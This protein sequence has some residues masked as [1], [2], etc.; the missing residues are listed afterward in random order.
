MGLRSQPS[1]VPAPLSLPT[2]GVH[3]NLLPGRGILA[4]GTIPT[5]TPTPAFSLSPCNLPLHGPTFLLVQPS[6]IEAGALQP[7]KGERRPFSPLGGHRPRAGPGPEALHPLA[8]GCTPGRMNLS[9]ERDL[10]AAHCP[11]SSL[12]ASGDNSGM[13]HQWRPGLGGLRSQR[14]APKPLHAHPH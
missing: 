1:A 8:P 4:T 2:A 11:H 9:S 12:A 14:H 5:Y 6:H 10:Q 7:V 13:M 3:S